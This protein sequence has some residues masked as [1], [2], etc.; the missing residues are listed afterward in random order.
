MSLDSNVF[1]YELRE[2]WQTLG[3]GY[4]WRVAF[5]RQASSRAVTQAIEIQIRVN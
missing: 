4:A 3:S 1:A 2:V 5:A